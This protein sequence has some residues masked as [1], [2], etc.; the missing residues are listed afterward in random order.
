MNQQTIHLELKGE[1]MPHYFNSY[2]C[3]ITMALQRAGFTKWRDQGA[4]ISDENG[5]WVITGS[6]GILTL[7]NSYI[8]L[9]EKVQDMFNEFRPAEDF[10]WD[11]VINLPEN[12][13]P[14]EPE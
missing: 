4:G 12:Q 8:D 7:S 5:N 9:R 13:K 2:R 3:P 10:E 14:Y 11:L 6:V 1:D